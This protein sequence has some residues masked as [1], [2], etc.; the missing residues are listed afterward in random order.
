MHDRFDTG[1]VN[2]PLARFL[3]GLRSRWKR[4]LGACVYWLMN[5]SIQAAKERHFAAQAVL[6]PQA[7]VLPEATIHNLAG[8]RGRIQVAAHTRLRGELLVFPQGG[9]ITIGESCY[10][11]QGSRIWSAAGIAI[12][13]RVLISHNVNIHDT[14]GHPLDA[15]ERHLHYMNIIQEGHPRAGDLDVKA[16]PITIGDDVWIGFN[17]IILKGVT[18]GP[19]VI[20]AAGSVI[21]KDIPPAVMVAGNPAKV[22]K[23]L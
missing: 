17:S 7:R 21:T 11:G 19:Q 14:N 20:I 4:R 23:T 1:W 8:E 6:D 13:H 2:H 22:I 16:E 3:Q 15:R 5:E 10:L 18:I 12:G 9:S